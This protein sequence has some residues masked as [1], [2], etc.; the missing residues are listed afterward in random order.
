[1][2][3]EKK[4]NHALLIVEDNPLLLSAY[5]KGF[6]QEGVNVFVAYGGE[7]GLQIVREQK[8]DVVLLDLAVH[9][10]GGLEVLKHIKSDPAIKETVVII[11]T[12]SEREEDHAEAIKLGA[13]AYLIKSQYSLEEVIG[14]VSKFTRPFKKG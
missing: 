2:T 13:D 10:M 14:L 8:P 7:E 4:K 12:M 11:F 3:E 9:G 5:Q 6:E 1:M